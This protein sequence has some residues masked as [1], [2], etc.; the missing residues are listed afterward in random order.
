MNFSKVKL[1]LLDLD[2]TLLDDQGNIGEQSKKYARL[3]REKGVI[4]T[5]ASGRMFSALDHYAAELSVD[6]PLI[7]SDGAVIKNYPGG[8]VFLKIGLKESKVKKGIDLSEKHLVKMVMCTDSEVL[9]TEHNEATLQ[10]IDRFG[11]KF[12]M[13]DNYRDVTGDIIE[14]VY[15]GENRQSFQEIKKHFSFPYS[16]GLK[17]A[18]SKSQSHFQYY[19]EVKKGEISKA[20]ALKVLLK[21]LNISIQDT[22]VVGDW[23]NDVALFKTNAIKVS[24]SN[25]VPEIKFLSD[26]KL[27]KSNNDDGVGELLE[28]IYSQK[29]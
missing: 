15:V 12:R 26:V 20:S 29:Q 4:V 6:G 11:A 3:L 1:V 27:E 17:L 5:F 9:Y 28:R 22:V 19:L 24:L 23:Y 8:D 16:F 21:K 10:L 13:V 14:L 18:Y 25:A 2:G 7:A